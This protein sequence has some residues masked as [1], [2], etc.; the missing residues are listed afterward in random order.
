KKSLASI[1]KKKT[2]FDGQETLNGEENKF[3]VI[4]RKKGW[5]E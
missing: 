2:G 4:L 5:I 3:E 1:I